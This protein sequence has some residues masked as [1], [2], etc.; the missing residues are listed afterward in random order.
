M[1][2]GVSALPTKVHSTGRVHHLQRVQHDVPA[3]WDPEPGTKHKGWAIYYI[4]YIIYIYALY[5]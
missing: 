2:V 4:Y 5:Q 3:V 1:F